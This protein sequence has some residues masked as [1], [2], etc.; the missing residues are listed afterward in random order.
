M[1]SLKLEKRK[2]KGKKPRKYFLTVQIYGD[3]QEEIDTISRYRKMC[4][5][6]NYT[7][8]DASLIAFKAMIEANGY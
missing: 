3:N 7:I 6:L 5:E 4:E 1:K 2:T 8:K